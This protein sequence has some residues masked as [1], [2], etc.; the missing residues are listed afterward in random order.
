[1]ERRKAQKGG[2]PVTGI[3]ERASI[4]ASSAATA[5]CGAAW[6]TTPV[7][8]VK[9]RIM[10]AAGEEVATAAIGNQARSLT[11]EMKQAAQKSGWSVAREVLRNEG[12]RGLFRGGLLR[13]VWTA[14]GSGLYLGV[15]EGGRFYLEDQRKAAQDDEGDSLMQKDWKNIKVGI[16]GSRSQDV[17]RKSQ[18]QDD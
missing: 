11:P 1:M 4:T 14:L 9:T 8:V 12:V 6:I 5:G 17:V 3:L 18:W 13:S 2:E 7:D 10:L 16:G 15:Y